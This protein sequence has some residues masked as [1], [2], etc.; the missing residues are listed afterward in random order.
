MPVVAVLLV[1]AS[2]ALWWLIERIAARS[3]STLLPATGSL[4]LLFALL[5]H[6]PG[7]GFGKVYVNEGESFMILGRA[8]AGQG[9][10][11]EALDYL[12][13]AA[14]RARTILDHPLSD[15]QA[16]HASRILST[17]LFEKGALLEKGARLPEALGA[18]T[19]A[20]RWTPPFTPE[21]ALLH[22]KSASLLDR[23]GQPGQAGRH[24]AEERKILETL[25]G[26]ASGGE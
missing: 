12:G 22:R 18:W 7:I 20:L 24:R 11:P 4:L 9:R 25:G 3:M 13:R 5:L 1:Y 19:E 10:T 21:R 2:F 23:M 6:V 16:S 14:Q 8:L 17:V 15:E 26:R